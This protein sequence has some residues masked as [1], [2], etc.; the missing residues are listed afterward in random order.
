MIRNTPIPSSQFKSVLA[1]NKYHGG[2]SLGRDLRSLL[3]A[4]CLDVLQA[5]QNGSNVGLIAV[6]VKEEPGWK[7]GEADFPFY[8]LEALY[9]EIVVHFPDHFKGGRVILAKKTGLADCAVFFKY[10][11]EF[12]PHT[13]NAF[14]ALRQKVRRIIDKR[15]SE[16]GWEAPRYIMGCA[17]FRQDGVKDA[18]AELLDAFRRALHMGSRP[19]RETQNKQHGLFLDILKNKRFEAVYQ[20]LADLHTGV[21]IGWEAYLRGPAGTPFETPETLLALAEETG[22]VCA[23]ERVFRELALA[24]LGE[25]APDQKLFLNIH[26]VSFSD[27]DFTPEEVLAHLKKHGL[28]PK[29][30]VFEFSERQSATDLDIILGKLDLFLKTG[31]GASIDDIGAGGMTLKALCR[32]RPDYLK[33]DVSIIGGIQSNPINRDMLKALRRLAETINSEVAAVGVETESELNAL[34]SLGVSLGQGFLLSEPSAPKP[35]HVEVVGEMPVPPTRKHG[36]SCST[37]V[38]ELVHESLTVAP[39]APIREVKRL[40]ENAPPMANVVVVEGKTPV[41]LLM[42]Y[43]L[44]RHLSTKYGLSLYY[45]RDVARLM[46][47]RPLVVEAGMPVEE[48]AAVAMGRKARNIYDDVIVT[49]RGAY[50]G[51]VSVQTML[52]TMAK[53]HVEIAKGSNPLTGLAGNVAIEQEIARRAN[54]KQP[55]SLV[56]IDLDNF[57]V[58]ND[59]YGFKNGDRII[60]YTAEIIRRAEADY[61]DPEDFIGHVGGDDF[62]LV[63]D[64]SRAETLCREIC[65]MFGEGVGKFYNNKD[66]ERG[67]IIGKGRDGKE[68]RFPLVSVSIGYIDCTFELPFAMEDLSR[69]VAEVKKYAKSRPGNSFVKDRRAPLGSPEDQKVCAAL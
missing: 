6:R 22:Q 65:R 46:D 39:G 51:T 67:Y 64:M 8:V 33:A 2:C 66:Q 56:Y 4:D 14:A 37:P 52:D 7:P 58:Y 28:R 31:V 49:E 30:I 1:Q 45:D 59:V 27:P 53:A 20:P 48:T 19:P 44:G 32:I 41:G 23:M 55:G 63:G 24:N 40:L 35:D 36:V 34:M 5:A 3:P 12:A 17:L 54:E 69:R 68:G 9:E 38:K 47:R 11:S 43:E 42:N 61:G 62:I 13:D 15:I 21:V 25:I 50:L 18:N 60:L 26:P 10:A 16:N 57:K 29:N